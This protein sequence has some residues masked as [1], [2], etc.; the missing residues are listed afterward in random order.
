[1]STSV[2]DADA[3]VKLL[4]KAKSSGGEL[5]FAFGLATKAEDC[6]LVID[7]RKPGKVLREQIK[8]DAA[9]KKT[10]FG[11][12]SVEETDVRLQPVK[13]LKGMVKQLKK[14]F[15]VE[16]M[17]KYNP[18]LLAEDGSILDEDMLPDGDEAEIEEGA[19]PEQP[20]APDPGGPATPSL[21]PALLKRR[22]AAAAT[23]IKGVPNPDLAKKLAPEVKACAQLLG[24]GDLPGCDARLT[25]LEAALTKLAARPETGSD[26]GPETGPEAGDGGEGQSQQAAKLKKLLLAQVA[27]LKTRPPA[28]AAPLALQAREIDAQLKAGDLTGAVAGLKALAAA[29]DAPVAQDAAPLSDP[30]GDP[31]AIWMAAKEDVDDGISALQSALRGQ[32]HPVLAK[33]ADAGLA[34]VT[35]GNQTALMKAL[36]EMKFSSGDARKTAA[37]ALLAQIA[38][39]STFL[40]SDPVIEL[41]ENNPFSISVPVKAPLGAALRQMAMIAKAA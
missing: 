19:G 31:M 1:M 21:D 11:V 39:Y 40:K 22:V 6:G 26:T 12:L 9:I 35:D 36:F 14:K 33:I 24:Q 20:G 18:I 27:K 13:P 8:K 15:R 38:A 34:G 4:K 37:K 28:Q 7:L 25:R 3:I 5:P 30:A 17:V 29:L 16:G 10:C 41:V 23:A 2:F 32:G